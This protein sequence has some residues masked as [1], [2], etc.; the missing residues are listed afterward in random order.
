MWVQA[1]GCEVG[2]SIVWDPDQMAEN[3]GAGRVPV[4]ARD[5]TP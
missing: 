1:G 2:A 3:S 5:S 4:G